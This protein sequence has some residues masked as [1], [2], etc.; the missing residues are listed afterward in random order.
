MLPMFLLI[1]AFLDS[2]HHSS[3]PK[4]HFCKGSEGTGDAQYICTEDTH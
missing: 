3:I 1:L 4:R 2:A